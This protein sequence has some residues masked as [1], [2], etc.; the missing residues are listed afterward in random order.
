MENKAKIAII[1]EG[2]SREPQL[3]ENLIKVFF[4]NPQY[5][6]VSLPAGQNIYMLW[7]QMVEDEFV[8]DIIEVVREYSDV[9]AERLE[10]LERDDFAEV[11]LFFDYDGHQNNLP[12]GYNGEEVLRQML[13]TFDDE[14]DNGKLYVSYPM[15]EAVRDFVPNTCKAFTTCVWNKDEI[16]TYKNKS[17]EKNPYRDIRDYTYITWCDIMSVYAMRV[18]CLFGKERVLSFEEYRKLVTPLTVFQQQNTYI[19]ERKVFVISAFPE[20]LL[21]YHKK[22]FW[23]K[24]IKQKRILSNCHS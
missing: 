5:V 13:E 6:I 8:T 2:T 3:L 24:H 22:D 23:N 12:N 19:A 7:R 15:V 16:N 10:G 18:S 20:F 21:E 4:K 11:Y 1:V 14:T 9:A 17:A